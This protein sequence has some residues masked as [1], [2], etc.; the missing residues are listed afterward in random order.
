MC[1]VCVSGENAYRFVNAV[2][3]CTH[4]C[5]VCITM[6]T[7]HATRVSMQCVRIVFMCAMR[8]QCVYSTC[9]VF[10]QQNVSICTAFVQ[11]TRCMLTVCAQYIPYTAYVDIVYSIRVQ[12]HVNC[13][14]TAGV[15][16]KHDTKLSRESL[17]SS[18]DY[19]SVPT[20]ARLRC[21]PSVIFRSIHSFFSG[22]SQQPHLG[23]HSTTA[24]LTTPK[25]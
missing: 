17:R 4:R 20:R 1:E 18:S 24:V 13:T 5:G 6:H 2:R 21:R 8:V 16:Q 14:R 19:C 7:C 23:P 9:S 22:R 10:V 12:Y 15:V 25:M 11:Y 3:R